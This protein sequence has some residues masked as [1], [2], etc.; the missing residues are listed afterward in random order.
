MRRGT[1]FANLAVLITA[2][3]VALAAQAS[4][5]PVQVITNWQMVE[6]VSETVPTTQHLANAFTLRS[7]CSNNRNT[8]AVCGRSNFR[9]L[10]VRSVHGTCDSMETRHNMA[11]CPT[12]KNR[13]GDSR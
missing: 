3:S 13:C 10:Q 6:R 1:L 12:K 8:S 7:S 4:A 9:K 2:P 5:K 11:T